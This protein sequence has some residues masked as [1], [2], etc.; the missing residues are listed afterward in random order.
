MYW[1][2]TVETIHHKFYISGHSYRVCDQN[3]GLI[4]IK[5]QLFQNIYVSDDRLQ[6]IKAAR[7]KSIQHYENEHS[8]STKK[9]KE[10]ITNRKVATE[11][12]KFIW[13]NIQWLKFNKINQ[14]RI[15]M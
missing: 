1:D 14:Y 5:T 12:S 6:A 9:L 2:F 8:L 3:F 11:H 7:Q 4:E 13:L 15:F 10:N